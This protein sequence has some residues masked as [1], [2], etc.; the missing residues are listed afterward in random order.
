M[1][2]IDQL[3]VKLAR[4][5]VPGYI[6]IRNGQRVRVGGYWRDTGDSAPPKNDRPTRGAGTKENPYRTHDVAEAARLLGEGH[7]VRLNRKREVSTLLNRLDEMVQDAKAKGDDAPNYDLCKVS[8]PHTNLFCE[9]SKGIPRI[10][11]P[12]LSGKPQ[13]GTPAANE[14]KFPRNQWGEANLGPSFIKFMKGKGIRVDDTTVDASYLKA[15][16]DQ[17][18]GAKVA[19][20]ET[21]IKKGDFDPSKGAIF[22]TSDDY[23]VDGHH[24]WAS[25][26]AAELRENKDVTLEVHRIDMDIISVLDMANKYA[27]KMGI[28][29]A[30]V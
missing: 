14:K 26:V 1:S 19:G 20:I 10:K 4:T 18:N 21:S 29:S 25:A 15:S 5:Y 16:Q 2:A 27:A 8:V 3:L 7:Y 13:E 12:Q 9:Q 28:A 24:R 6:A 30:G 22:V 23:I 11:M 17:L